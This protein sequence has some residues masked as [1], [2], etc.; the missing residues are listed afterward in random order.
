MSDLL[1]KRT[2]AD[3]IL[4]GE[5]PDH[6]GPYIL[7][8]KW[9]RLMLPGEI[10]DRPVSGYTPSDRFQVLSGGGGEDR[11]FWAGPG[12]LEMFSRRRVG[13]VRVPDG[14]DVI[15]PND[16]TDL[17]RAYASGQG[18]P[19]E[20]DFY[21]LPHKKYEQNTFTYNLPGRK[22][23][24]FVGYR[25]HSHPY[26][27]VL[28]PSVFRGLRPGDTEPYLEYKRRE[29][30][31][32][33]LLREAYFRLREQ[34]L[35]DVQAVGILQ[36]H[37]TIGDTD[38]LDLTYDVDTAKL[39]ALIDLVDGNNIYPK[40]W[41]GEDDYSSVYKIIVRPLGGDDPPLELP[42]PYQ[43]HLQLLPYNI[44]PLSA[45]AETGDLERGFGAWGFG[46]GDLDNFGTVLNITEWRYHPT[47]NPHG[48]GAIG[49]VPDV[50][51]LAESTWRERQQLLGLAPESPWLEELL[52]DVRTRMASRLPQ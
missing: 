40:S 46:P 1:P 6:C 37:K 22:F 27:N 20:G 2:W 11:R 45:V 17:W 29:G 34:P 19:Y 42:P 8:P 21:M 44:V 36:H 12:M 49:G 3:R 7:S 31:A 32:T 9:R 30:Y 13:Y 23:S 43:G 47:S 24:V 10:R 16:W 48:W 25:G 33:D 51:Q 15:T 18:F 35:L 14:E 38:V 4:D 28:T 50:E 41:R 39:F 52:S 5:N 26:P